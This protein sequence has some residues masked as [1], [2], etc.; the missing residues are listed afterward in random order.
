[1]SKSDCTLRHMYRRAFDLAWL[2]GRSYV[3]HTGEESLPIALGI[4]T[5]FIEHHAG[6]MEV[7]TEYSAGRWAFIISEAG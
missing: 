7:R 2:D 5:E 4:A 1:V 6:A 3:C